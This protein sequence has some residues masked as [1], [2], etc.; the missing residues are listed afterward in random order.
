MEGERVNE[1]LSSHLRLGLP[2]G[3]FPSGFPTK[4]LYTPLPS[5][6]RATCPAHLIL[7]DFITH[8]IHYHGLKKL[9][10]L[11]SNTQNDKLKFSHVTEMGP[12]K[13]TRI[14]SKKS[15]VMIGY[16]DNYIFGY[17]TYI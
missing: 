9:K 15:I 17:H 6:I 1:I 13:S 16:H 11:W 5:P 4:T 12:G 8:T 10:L 7:L 2:S 14:I 3:L